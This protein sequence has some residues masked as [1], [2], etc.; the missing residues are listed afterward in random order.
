MKKS[1][2]V[3][4]TILVS[5]FGLTA[6]AQP[7]FTSDT[8]ARRV[9]EIL[10]MTP[11]TVAFEFKNQGTEPLVITEVHPSC[12][13]VKV[14]WPKTAVAAGQTGVITAIYD[15][16]QLGTFYRELA[17]YTNQQSEPFYLGFQG[18]VVETAMDYDGDFPIDLGNVRL[19]TNYVE[20]DNV[21]R[22]DK[23]VAELQIANMEHGNYTPQLMHLPDYLTAEYLPTEIKGGRVGRLRLTLDSEQLT[24]D[25][26]NQTSIYLARYMGDKVSEANEI[27]VSSVLL[28]AFPHLTAEEMERAPHIVLMDGDEMLDGELNMVS[29]GK[30]RVTR[31]VNVTNI[32][33]EPLV[34]SAVQVFNRAMTVSLGDRNIAPHGTTK[35]KITLDMKEL[36]RAKSGPRLLLISNDPRQ[37]KIVLSLNV[38]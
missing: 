18:R 23:P 30:K 16:R 1:Y 12:G 14:E 4:I 37:A 20:F 7:R 27:L 28:P 34:V 36:Q 13:C 31:I 26:L 35:L 6:A 38:E 17:V 19:N 8:Q 9:G 24:I 5:L 32:G 10:F 22:G 21:S 29:G 3:I 33:E 15:A 25:G 2:I 11:K